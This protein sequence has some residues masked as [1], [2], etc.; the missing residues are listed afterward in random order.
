MAYPKIR[1]KFKVDEV[2]CFQCPRQKEPGK[3]W[4]PDNLETVE[5]RTVM[6]SPVYANDSPT[7]YA[8]NHE[9]TKFWS[10]TPSGTVELAMINPEAW[11]HFKL[12]REYYLDFSPCEP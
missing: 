8:R 11:E 2:R 10:A 9:N 7:V 4:E 12:G 1:A 6:M 5:M 3:G